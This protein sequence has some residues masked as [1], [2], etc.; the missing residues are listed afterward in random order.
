MCRNGVI[1]LIHGE[2]CDDGNTYSHDGCSSNCRLETPAWVP[3]QTFLPR[4]L[5]AIAYDS[6]RARI[7][8]YGGYVG[9]TNF[10][11]DQFEWDGHRWSSIAIG[12]SPGVRL[13]SAM[14]YDEQRGVTVLFGGS[15]GADRND[16]W[17]WDGA[18]WKVVTPT[19]LLPPASSTSENTQSR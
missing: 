9:R 17:E 1:D 12:V 18:T 6:R 5:P 10:N 4:R 19:G 11:G 13:D 2:Q 8:V 3:H 7:A 14:A 15:D 16:T